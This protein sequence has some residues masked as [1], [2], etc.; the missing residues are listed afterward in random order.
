MDSA[1]MPRRKV[2]YRLDDRVLDELDKLVTD[3]SV[4]QFVEG[5]LFEFLKNTGRLPGDAQRLP[6][7]RGGKRSGAGKPKQSSDDRKSKT[8]A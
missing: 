3:G 1:Q 4:N 8:E 5:I 7:N 6:D 2:T